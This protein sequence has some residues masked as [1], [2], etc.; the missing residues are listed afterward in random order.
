VSCLSKYLL[1]LFLFFFAGEAF[2][3][4]SVTA[5]GVAFGI[6]DIFAA[7][8]TASTG[9]VNISCDKVKGKKP[10][11]TITISQSAHSGTF[12]PRQMKNLSGADLLNY[13]LYTDKTTTKVWGNG[14]GGTEAV[15]IKATKKKKMTIYGSIPAGQIVGVGSYS[16]NLTVTVTP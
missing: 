7:A 1:T 6:Y 10:D 2:A 8:P 13:N 5:T 12:N 14:T 16:D 3:A 4:C 15:I 9:T 11:A